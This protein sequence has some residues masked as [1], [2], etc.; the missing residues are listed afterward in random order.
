LVIFDLHL[1]R[2]A[3]ERQELSGKNMASTWRGYDVATSWRSKMGSPRTEST[4]GRQV[5]DRHYP[6]K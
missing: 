1:L 4:A 3:I 6:R 2:D 5:A